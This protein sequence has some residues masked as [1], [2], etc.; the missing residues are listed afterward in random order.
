MR[1]LLQKIRYLYYI[2]TDQTFHILTNYN[3]YRYGDIIMFS[4]GVKAEVLTGSMHGDS[5]LYIVR[6]IKDVVIDQIN[7]E[8]QKLIY[9]I[10]IWK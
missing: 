5:L 9:K 3:G 8:Q 2:W 7:I 6:G 4:E 1:R 10:G